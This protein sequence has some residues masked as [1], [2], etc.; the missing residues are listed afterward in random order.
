MLKIKE[1]D[2]YHGV[3]YTFKTAEKKLSERTADTWMRLIHLRDFLDE[4]SPRYVRA[5][6]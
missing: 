5:T 6:Q 2:L 1:T 4:Q 3:K